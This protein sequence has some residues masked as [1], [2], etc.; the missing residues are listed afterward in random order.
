[1]ILSLFN[2][3]F[4]FIKKKI[5]YVHILW[6]MKKIRPSVWT[7]SSQPSG[8]GP[9][10]SISLLGV[11]DGAIWLG[12]ELG[13]PVLGSIQVVVLSLWSI[14]NILPLGATC[15]PHP[16]GNPSSLDMG[17]IGLGLSL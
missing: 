2:S 8:S 17:R 14:K 1:M 10:W 9:N 6:S 7:L 11:V 3:K 4:W 12:I 16:G 15:M 5:I 13:L